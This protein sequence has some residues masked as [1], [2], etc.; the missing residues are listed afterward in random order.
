[1]KIIAAEISIKNL[2]LKYDD[3]SA[4]KAPYG[5]DYSHLG[6]QQLSLN[7]SNLTYS[8]DTIQLQFNRQV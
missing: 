1:M 2:N 8:S 7:A 4:P 5:M 3:Q 6:I